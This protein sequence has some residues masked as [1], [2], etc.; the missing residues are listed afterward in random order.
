VK[1]AD[2]HYKVKLHRGYEDTEEDFINKIEK[3][4]NILEDYLSHLKQKY[5]NDLISERNNLQEKID[6]AANL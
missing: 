5:I 3:M 2:C 6:V 1:I 4:K